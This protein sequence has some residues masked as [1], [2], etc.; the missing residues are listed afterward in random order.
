MKEEE[1]T[2]DIY[3]IT[4]NA[5][6]RQKDWLLESGILKVLFLHLIIFQNVDY[7]NINILIL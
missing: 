7:Y 6:I 4:I 5:C 2:L 3:E 1:Y